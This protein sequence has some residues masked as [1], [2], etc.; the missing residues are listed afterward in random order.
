MTHSLHSRSFSKEEVTM[1]VEGM[2]LIPYTCILINVDE[3]VTV[4]CR[5]FRHVFQSHY[6]V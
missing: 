3:R 6:H 2:V 1:T 5:L 4:S